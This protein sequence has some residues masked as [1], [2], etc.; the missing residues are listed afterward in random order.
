MANID[1]EDVL[2]HSHAIEIVQGPECDWDA[3]LTCSCGWDG[4]PHDYG[5]HLLVV[6]GLEDRVLADCVMK[7]EPA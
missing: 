6:L 7:K 5:A 3:V 2:L 1:L 4:G